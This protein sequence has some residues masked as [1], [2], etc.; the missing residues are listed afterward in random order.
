MKKAS[1]WAIAFIAILVLPDYHLKADDKTDHER[2]VAADLMSSFQALD[3][4]RDG[5]ITRSEARGDLNF[6]PHFDDMDINRDDVVTIAELQRFIHL[7]FGI[8]VGTP[9]QAKV[10]PR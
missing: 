4:N 2:R 6:V 3:L 10:S 9:D 1:M 8:V 7:R 5:M